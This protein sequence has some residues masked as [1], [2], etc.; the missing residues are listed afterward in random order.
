ML[1]K[2]SV[3]VY[4]VRTFCLRWLALRSAQWHCVSGLCIFA[5]EQP[6]FTSVAC[7]ASPIELAVNSAHAHRRFHRERNS[8][9]EKTV[10]LGYDARTSE[11][12]TF[13]SELWSR[14]LNCPSSLGWI[15][16]PL[17]DH[18]RLQMGLLS[19]NHQVFGYVFVSGASCL[20]AAVRRTKV[21]MYVADV[22]MRG[23]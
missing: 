10:L 11:A 18:K 17:L 4:K 23:M 5:V 6:V 21:S 19:W 15:G 12:N 2:V 3:S 16:D 1:Y 8:P 7:R 20:Y 14:P 22:V 9:W 13:L